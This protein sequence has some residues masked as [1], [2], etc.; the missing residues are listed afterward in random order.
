[1]ATFGNLIRE[2][3]GPEFRQYTITATATALSAAAILGDSR[4]PRKLT[5]KNADGAANACYL[6][7][8]NVAATPTSAGIEL[9]AGDSYTFNDQS[10]AAIFIIGTPPA[11]NIAFIVAEA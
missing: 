10:P 9:G 7:S 3:A 11:A 6:G 5:V 1:M 2:A 4:A 8:S